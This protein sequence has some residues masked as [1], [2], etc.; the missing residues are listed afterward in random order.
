MDVPRDRWESLH[1][2]FGQNSA[3][4][5]S[6]VRDDPAAVALWKSNAPTTVDHPLSIESQS[7]DIAVH[8]N[9]TPHLDAQTR[10]V[11]IDV[12]ASTSQTGDRRVVKS[13]VSFPGDERASTLELPASRPGP[14]VRLVVLS[15]ERG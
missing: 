12:E 1:R 11:T 13:T 4:L 14:T 3:A 6:A 10:Q 7:S 15:I 9:L 8:C 5:A 2:Q